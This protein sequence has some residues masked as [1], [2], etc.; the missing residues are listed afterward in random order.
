MAALGSGAHAWRPPRRGVDSGFLSPT[1]TLRSL[2]IGEGLAVLTLLLVA[3]LPGIVDG[4]WWIGSAVALIVVALASCLRSRRVPGVPLV[5]VVLVGL[6]VAAGLH[7]QGLRIDDVAREVVRPLFALAVA[8]VITTSAQRARL[9]LAVVAVAIVQVPVTAVQTID[10]V[11]RFGRHATNAVDSV[12]GTLGASQ[13]GVVTL[14][15]LLAVALGLGAWVAGVVDKR[16]L[17]LLGMLVAVGVFTSTRAVIAFV[18]AMTVALAAVIFLSR[19]PQRFRLRLAG[20]V[21]SALRTPPHSYRT[22]DGH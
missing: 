2:S 21:V 17:L 8:I 1:A 22:I 12:T 18:P 7:G 13:S 15:A 20:A 11:V 16:V 9:L 6:I 19:P 5:C 14:L 10:H 3:V 4:R